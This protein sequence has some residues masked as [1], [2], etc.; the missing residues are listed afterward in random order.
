MNL[1]V[2]KYLQCT[3]GWSKDGQPCS[4]NIWCLPGLAA[5][6]AVKLCNKYHVSKVQQVLDYIEPAC[7]LEDVPNGRWHD[8]MC[9]LHPSNILVLTLRIAGYAFL[10][11][12]A[13]VISKKF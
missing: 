6:S 5:K 8:G 11:S 3:D 13:D 2:I 12:C 1:Q 10:W 9:A 4:R 7:L